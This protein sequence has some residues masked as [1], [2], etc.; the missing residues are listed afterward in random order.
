MF[1]IISRTKFAKPTLTFRGE[2]DVSSLEQVP[3]KAKERQP[4]QYIESRKQWPH[5]MLTLSLLYQSFSTLFWQAK[6]RCQCTATHFLSWIRKEE[7]RPQ[8]RKKKK[9][10][11]L[12]KKEEGGFPLLR[13]CYDYF[14]GSS[15]PQRRGREPVQASLLLQNFCCCYC[16]CWPPQA[17]CASYFPVL[18]FMSVAAAASRLLLR[19][20]LLY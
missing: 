2:C 16:C 7:G 4:L 12:A 20:L 18:A 3:G 10:R 17:T 1:S 5:C 14:D 13:V 15:L 11:K 9:H 6:L 19:Q 8:Y